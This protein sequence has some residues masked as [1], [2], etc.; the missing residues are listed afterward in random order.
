MS[1]ESPE[2]LATPQGVGKSILTALT[3]AELALLLDA[4]LASLA[5]SSLETALKGL[6]SDTRKTL[7]QILTPSSATEVK[8]EKPTSLAK[9]EQT[10]SDLWKQ[11]ND[12]ASEATDEEGKYIQQ[13][14]HWEPP[15]FDD[16]T[17]VD[18]LEALAEQ[19]LPLLS[20]AYEHNFSP[21]A[22]FAQTLEEMAAEII[23]ALPEWIQL[24]NEGLYLESSL[25]T[26]LLEWQWLKA[27]DEGIDAFGF[28][29]WV[30]EWEER[31]KLVEL[32]QSG[33]FNFFTRLPDADLEKIYQGLTAHR[34]TLFWKTYLENTRSHW[35]ELYL[36]C[37]EKYGSSVLV[38][39][40]I[41][42]KQKIDKIVS[43]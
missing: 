3:Q 15:Y 1:P 23:D 9:L 38:M 41:N 8:A 24:A 37:L 12:I 7:Q 33:F 5:P 42:Q 32:E 36:Y 13:E 35:Y 39:P 14:E 18:D 10:W 21:N 43:V 25:T 40:I 11:W 20:T 34:G 6:P 30:R 26:C 27:Q 4:L 22:D 19:M 17:L 28:T 29:Q 31:A 2:Q 16:N